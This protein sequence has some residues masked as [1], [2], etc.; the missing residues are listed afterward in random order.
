MNWLPAGLDKL[1]KRVAVFLVAAGA[2]VAHCLDVQYKPHVHGC[3]HGASHT[4]TL[5]PSC[6]W[7]SCTSPP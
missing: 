4:L 1:D 5:G 2:M 7:C 6:P 3:A